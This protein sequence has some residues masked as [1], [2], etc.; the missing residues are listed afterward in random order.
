MRDWLFTK[1]EI[2]NSPS[3]QDGVDKETEDRYRREGVRFLTEVGT[4]LKLSPHPTLATAA[5]YFHR[6]YMYHSF[7]EFSRHL[8]ALGC[9]FLAG[10]T[11]E[12]PKKCRDI[13]QVAKEKLSEK[14][15]TQAFGT[16]T[17]R[18]PKEEVMSVE[19]VL[20]QTIKFD[21]QIE[22]PY[23]YLLKYAK[24]LK[25]DKEKARNIVQMAW[26][27]V[28]DSLCTT[29]CL[30]WEP[31]VIAIALMYLATRLSKVEVKDWHNRMGK[32]DEKWWDTLVDDLEMDLM[33]DICHQVLDLY[34]QSAASK[35]STLSTGSS[36]TSTPKT[37][38][39]LPT[40]PAINT[41][42]PPPSTTPGSVRPPPPPPSPAYSQGGQHPP[43]LPQSAPPAYSRNG[44]IP[45]P[46]SVGGPPRQPL[47][48]QPLL[49]TPGNVARPGMAYNPPQ[50]AQTSSNLNQPSIHGSRL[51]TRFMGAHRGQ[52]LR[53]PATAPPVMAG[54]H[55]PPPS[56]P[57]Q[58][59][60]PLAP[61][62]GYG[63]Q[64]F[65][66]SVPQQQFPHRPHYP[67]H[68]EG[69]PQP[70]QEPPA[71]PDGG[72]L[73]PQY[74]G[75]EYGDYDQSS[76]TEYEQEMP[77]DQGATEYAEYEQPQ[78]NYGWNYNGRP[79]KKSVGKLAPLRSLLEWGQP[80]FEKCGR[81]SG[82]W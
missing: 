52:E 36:Q 75:G 48:Q 1:T 30:Q 50:Y 44:S 38:A 18:D 14:H 57:P 53:A 71:Q 37:P 60:A 51:P 13:V 39:S 24:V 41:L 21:L 6:F 46:H 15:W 12:T 33:E 16:R 26:T 54:I 25:I 7:K 65:G 2:A 72:Y 29:L 80:P 64:K 62:G 79:N 47:A 61:M 10:K 11:E 56:F 68:P 49:L 27:F 67:P 28:N 42:P 20:L 45:P 9:L 22:H 82:F 81:V 23:T 76:Y 5:V 17:D 32:K 34:Q 8:T 63:Q 4:E 78:N 70:P 73:P 40:S 31:E 77:Y 58:H 19:R 3:G 66:E 74:Q 43:Q 69:Y 55:Q 35:P 59:S